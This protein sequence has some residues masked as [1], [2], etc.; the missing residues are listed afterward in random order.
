MTPRGGKRPGAGRPKGEGTVTMRMPVSVRPAAEALQRIGRGEG[1]EADAAELARLADPS[2]AIKAEP[3]TSKA[4]QRQ[5]D[6]AIE[7]GI[8]AGL[9]EAIAMMQEQYDRAAAIEAAHAGVFEDAEYRLL[10]SALH[11][12]RCQPDQAEKFAK[13][14]HLL[15]SKEALLCRPKPAAGPSTLPSSLAEFAARR[16]GKGAR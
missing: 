5:I 10:L 1:T 4:T 3:A 15:K 6:A 7:A 8:Q 16:K 13:A 2:G 14:F 11:P 9:S 12:D